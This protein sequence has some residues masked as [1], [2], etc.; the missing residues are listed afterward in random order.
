[1]YMYINQLIVGIQ[2]CYIVTSIRELFLFLL[3]FYFF[4]FLFISIT[5]FFL[6]SRHISV[7]LGEAAPVARWK[8]PVETAVDR[9]WFLVYF[10]FLF[11]LALIFRNI[12]YTRRRTTSIGWHIKRKQHLDQSQRDN[13]YVQTRKRGE[14]YDVLSCIIGVTLGKKG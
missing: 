7:V 5:S 3:S 10:F 13:S 9:C 4:I 2:L 1:M 14:E 6:L 11:R 12:C 8:I